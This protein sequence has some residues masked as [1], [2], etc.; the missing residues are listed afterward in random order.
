MKIL[1]SR[2]VVDANPNSAYHDI[3]ILS[4]IR[5]E[6]MNSFRTMK[7]FKEL[8]RVFMYLEFE[9][10]SK[11]QVRFLSMLLSLP[12][13]GG[14]GRADKFLVTSRSEEDLDFTASEINS[15]MREVV[16]K[17]HKN[18]ID[19]GF[20]PLRPDEWERALLGFMKSTS[21]AEKVRIVKFEV[22]EE[23][24]KDR[25]YRSTG[26]KN[27]LVGSTKAVVGVVKRS[28]IFR[29]DLKNKYN[30]AETVLSTGS[31]N[32]PVKASRAIFPVPLTVLACQLA[33]YS[34]ISSYITSS[35]GTYEQEALI[36]LR[37]SP[38]DLMSPSD[39]VF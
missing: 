25:I 5:E 17:L 38:R 14:Y 29:G 7:N 26:N 32:V 36:L 28:I 24:E 39:H 20:H 6:M 13:M 18:S 1:T 9:P 4:E 2:R 21:A 27:V 19:H 35:H 12:I 34:H 3:A 37:V 10:T 31:R 33:V 15:E 22:T 23:R 16:G 30:S 11:E 8:S